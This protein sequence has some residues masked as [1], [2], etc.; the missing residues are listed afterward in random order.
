MEDYSKEDEVSQNAC[1][2]DCEEDVLRDEEFVINDNKRRVRYVVSEPII[3]YN[4][5]EMSRDEMKAFLKGFLD[6][7]K[8]EKEEE[9]KIS[10][11]E[12]L[13]LLLT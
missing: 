4:G 3:R 1:E 5:M 13:T 6:G 9:A 10:D 2:V 8:K 12:M 11:A 7:I